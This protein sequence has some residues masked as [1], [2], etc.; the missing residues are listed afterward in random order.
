M[1][2]SMTIED[3]RV[4]HD[5]TAQ[6]EKLRRDLASVEERLAKVRDDSDERRRRREAGARSKSGGATK[7]NAD[8][9]APVL[10]GQSNDFPT[11]T[12]L[13]SE[14]LATLVVGNRQSQDGTALIVNGS[15]RATRGDAVFGNAGNSGTG[16]VGLSFGG[17]GV[18]GSSNVDVGVKASS[19]RHYAISA[20]SSGAATLFALNSSSAAGDCVIAVADNGIGVVAMGSQ[21]PLR[22]FPADTAGAPQ[23]GSHFKGELV[24]DLNG[25]LYLCVQD[26]QPGTWR[27]IG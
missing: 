26:G 17:P 18:E 27:K 13:T 19:A 11:A 21:A 8:S 16:V 6:I 14:D 4:E 5:L 12:I 9:S 1:R 25:D 20:T 3:S 10:G 15:D 22:L 2:R 7:S 23:S 24:V